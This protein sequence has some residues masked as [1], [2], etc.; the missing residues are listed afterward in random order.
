MT[1]DWLPSSKTRKTRRGICH[2][3]GPAVSAAMSGVRRV[4]IKCFDEQ[5]DAP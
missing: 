2:L 1:A 4:L 3:G 5:S